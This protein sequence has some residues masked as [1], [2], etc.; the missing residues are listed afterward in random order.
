MNFFQV[1]AGG[2]RGTWR[3][4]A[5]PCCEDFRDFLGLHAA[6]THLDDCAYNIAH[7]LALVHESLDQPRLPGFGV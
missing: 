7:H 4:G 5:I 6:F 2:R 3:S 1:Q